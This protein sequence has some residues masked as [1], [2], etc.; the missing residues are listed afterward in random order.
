VLTQLHPGA[1]VEQAKAATGWPLRV[2]EPLPTTESP[3]EDELKV[4]RELTKGQ[5]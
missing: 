5:S 4:L 3:A 1:T 2:R